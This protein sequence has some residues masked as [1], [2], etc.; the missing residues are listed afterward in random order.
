MKKVLYILGA[1]I[2]TSALTPASSFAAKSIGVSCSR[3]GSPGNTGSIR[4]INTN[5]AVC[6]NC[7]V[8]GGGK[9]WNDSKGHYTTP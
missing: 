7:S 6:N 1:F 4:D 9:T 2:L 8:K 5:K 3:C